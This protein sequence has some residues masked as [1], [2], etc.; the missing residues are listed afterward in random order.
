MRPYERMLDPSAIVISGLERV[1]LVWD[2]VRISEQR[3]ATKLVSAQ[4]RQRS[5]VDA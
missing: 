1:G 5:W 3:Q 2:V 4:R